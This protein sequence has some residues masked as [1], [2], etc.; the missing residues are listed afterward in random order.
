M[1]GAQY[2]PAD[3]TPIPTAVVPPGDDNAGASGPSASS[4]SLSMNDSQTAANP[5]QTASQGASAPAANGG[6]EVNSASIPAVPNSQV[7]A[8]TSGYA[9]AI[10][11][12]ARRRFL[13]RFPNWQYRIIRTD[14]AGLLCGLFAVQ[15]MLRNE[16]GVPEP[17]IREL[18]EIHDVHRARQIAEIFQGE[19]GFDQESFDAVNNQH[20]LAIDQLD[21]IVR[22][23]GQRWGVDLRIGYINNDHE[24]VMVSR[25]NDNLNDQSQRMIWLHHN[26][27]GVGHYS[28]IAPLD[29]PQNIDESICFY[30]D[31]YLAVNL[32][33]IGVI[34][35]SK[36]Y[37]LP[38][39][40]DGVQLRTSFEST[41]FP[42]AL[43][44][45]IARP[46]DWNTLANRKSNPMELL[47]VWR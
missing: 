19:H 39:R 17:T 4:T 43:E 21:N 37:L 27:A 7:Q 25:P 44:Q 6:G 26:N 3:T 40:T 11:R 24:A 20:T 8:P 47:C 22:V 30:D 9:A 42:T 38:M 18:L 34:L 35:V 5:P 36:Q 1:S 45:T 12:E 23:F 14:S 29:G 33:N 15:T 16:P 28:A 10:R 13:A 41:G 32:I 31:D 46:I 2:E